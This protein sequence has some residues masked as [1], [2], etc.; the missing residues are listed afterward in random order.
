MAPLD[1][2]VEVLLEI[3]AP[4]DAVAAP[5][6]P[7]VLADPPLPDGSPLP[8]PVGVT[9]TSPAQPCA[10]AIET[11][12]SSTVHATRS[13]RWFMSSPVPSVVGPPQ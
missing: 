7:V 1:D 3:E 10:T 8:P 5:P 4:L 2:D 12:E 6:V 11:H 9:V 13:R